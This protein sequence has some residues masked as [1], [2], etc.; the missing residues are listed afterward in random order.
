MKNCIEYAPRR[1]TMNCVKYHEF[2][3]ISLNVSFWDSEMV[4]L[5]ILQFISYNKP[6]L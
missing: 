1:V 5:K 4:L 6:R 3:Y 2:E